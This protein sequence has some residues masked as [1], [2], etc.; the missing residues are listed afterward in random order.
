MKSSKLVGVELS[1]CC[2]VDE[3]RRRGRHQ[4]RSDESCKILHIIVTRKTGNNL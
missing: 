3:L 1:G 2:A 4:E